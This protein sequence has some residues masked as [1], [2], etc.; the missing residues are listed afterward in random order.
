MLRLPLWTNIGKAVAREMGARMGLTT[1]LPRLRPTSGELLHLDLMR[2]I[3]SAGIVFHH[4][5]EFFVP[6][7]KS[8]FL[9]R[10]QTAGLALFVDLFFVISGFVIAYI[11][12]NRMSSIIDYFTFLQ[13]RVGRRNCSRLIFDRGFGEVV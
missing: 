2:F 11:Y 7:T 4:S 9:A 10:E 6:I 13:R 8:P 1:R 5:H 3:A 12:H